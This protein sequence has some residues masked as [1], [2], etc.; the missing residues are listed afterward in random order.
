MP[1][2]LIGAPAENPVQK[3]KT[4]MS[5]GNKV[6]PSRTVSRPTGDLGSLP[7]LNPES[8]R[9][10]SIANNN[11]PPTVPASHARSGMADAGTNG[12]G[13]SSLGQRESR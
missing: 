13:V 9:S 4:N 12:P 1:S 2:A 3:R 11:A 8:G 7:P 6:L 5:M 10:P